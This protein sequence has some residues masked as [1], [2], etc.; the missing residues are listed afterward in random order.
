MDLVVTNLVWLDVAE[1]AFDCMVSVDGDPEI[2]YTVINGD[3]TALAVE[4]WTRATSGEFGPIAGY[5][6]PPLVPYELSVSVFWTR[7][8]DTEAD[9]FDAAMSVAPPL[10]LRKVFNTSQVL[11][12]QTELFDFVRG[13]LVTVVSETRADEILA[14]G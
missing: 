10:R 12:S 6:A 1:T 14:Q 13:V 4:L 11:T 2:P 3:P 5:V 7:M 8:S 9:E